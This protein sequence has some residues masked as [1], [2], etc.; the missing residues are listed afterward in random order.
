M[1]SGMH[2]VQLPREPTDPSGMTI[3]G[4][5]RLALVR[6]LSGPNLNG[7]QPT[8]WSLGCLQVNGGLSTLRTSVLLRL[9]GRL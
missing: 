1:S 4:P 5:L 3:S 8:S 6:P 9:E 2:T 7:I